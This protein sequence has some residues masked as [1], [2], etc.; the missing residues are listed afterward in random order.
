MLTLSH[1]LSAIFLLQKWNC[2]F[3][4]EINRECWKVFKHFIIISIRPTV[5]LKMKRPFAVFGVKLKQVF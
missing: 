4:T 3:V 5:L 2:T 1:D